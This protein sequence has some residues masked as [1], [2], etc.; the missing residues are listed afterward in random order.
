MSGKS[1]GIWADLRKQRKIKYE[2]GIS[3]TISMQTSEV[4]P[5]FDL[6]AG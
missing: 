1:D 5:A 6:C 3:W 4:I 2:T